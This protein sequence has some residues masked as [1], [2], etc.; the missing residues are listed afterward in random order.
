[1]DPLRG[2]LWRLSLWKRIFFLPDNHDGSTFCHHVGNVCD[3]GS[4]A[5]LLI[6]PILLLLTD[7]DRQKEY[8]ERISLTS[9]CQ[10]IQKIGISLMLW[11]GNVS[12]EPQSFVSIIDSRSQEMD[13]LP[14]LELLALFFYRKLGYFDQI[15]IGIPR[16]QKVNILSKFCSI[17]DQISEDIRVLHR[18][19]GIF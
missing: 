3:I 4:A 12:I 11:K 6:G 2:K 16:W 7:S 15:F 10:V 8:W 14:F 9:S 18:N 13:R 1:M 17:F 19:N 5:I